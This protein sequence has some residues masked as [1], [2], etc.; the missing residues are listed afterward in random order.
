MVLVPA[1]LTGKAVTLDMDVPSKN[2]EIATPSNTPPT[3]LIPA[4]PNTL[5]V[6]LFAVDMKHPKR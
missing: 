3:M 1:I 4:C 5:T 2:C 6:T